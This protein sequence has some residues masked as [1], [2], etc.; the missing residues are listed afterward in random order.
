VIRLDDEVRA[1]YA[2]AARRRRDDLV[3]CCYRT[4]IEPVLANREEDVVMQLVAVFARR[5]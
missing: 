1:R 5:G 4:G 3:R 2:A